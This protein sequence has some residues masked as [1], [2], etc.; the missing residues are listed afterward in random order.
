MLYCLCLF[1]CNGVQHLL[2]CVFVLHL[3][4]P[5]LPISL[6]CPFFFAPSVFSNVYL[7]HLI[8]YMVDLFY[9][10]TNILNID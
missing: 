8:E 3:V 6:D 5:V 1:A 7:L 9:H 4:C 10:S 2:R